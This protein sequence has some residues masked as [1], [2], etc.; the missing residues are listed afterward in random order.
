[1]ILEV[2]PKQQVDGK[3]MVS[4][5]MNRPDQLDLLLFLDLGK[6]GL[7]TILR[8]LLHNWLGSAGM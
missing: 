2:N 8:H 7:F 3:S 4:N 6:Y 5:T 1:V